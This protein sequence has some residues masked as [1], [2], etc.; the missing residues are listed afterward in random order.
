[1]EKLQADASSPMSLEGHLQKVTSAISE[2]M[3]GGG[4]KGGG[5]AP[6]GGE[7]AFIDAMIT[8]PVTGA[9]SM[10]ISVY[11]QMNGGQTPLS[12]RQNGQKSSFLGS[13]YT[14]QKATPT[15]LVPMSYGQKRAAHK[16]ANKLAGQAAKKDGAA[17]RGSSVFASERIA[18]ASMSL[19]GSSMAGGAARPIKG[20]QIDLN[21]AAAMG[22]G[23]LV[24]ELNVTL[25]K[26][27]GVNRYD[28]DP[29]RLQSDLRLGKESAEMAVKNS[30]S[31]A[32]G[33]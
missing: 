26:M 3:Q 25:R 19:T 7:D 24:Q 20:A 11:D 17:A 6:G 12:A 27:Q 32:K 9:G 21:A 8:T 10:F 23:G 22:F 15:P 31:M 30:P 13:G 1:M 28:N 2:G 18:L 33:L 29:R 16:R 4:A 5:A 14:G